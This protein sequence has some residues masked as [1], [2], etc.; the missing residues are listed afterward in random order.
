MA[1]NKNI[2]EPQVKLLEDLRMKILKKYGTVQEDGSIKIPN[3]I[4]P[5]A[6]DELNELFE[7]REEVKIITL[8]ISEF[9][10]LKL[11]LANMSGLMHMI[12]IE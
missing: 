11:N 5:Q 7:Q 4:A 12:Y 10:D 3:D 8:P 2:L 1:K 6:V 9:G